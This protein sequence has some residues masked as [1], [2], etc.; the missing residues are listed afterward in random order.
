MDEV[1]IKAAFL[2]ALASLGLM[3]VT[4]SLTDR[5]NGNLLFYT[6]SGLTIEIEIPASHSKWN[7]TQNGMSLKTECHS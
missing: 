5:P 2:D 4:Q 3:I 1:Q 7:A 6:T